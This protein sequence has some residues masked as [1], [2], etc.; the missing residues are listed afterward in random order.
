MTSKIAASRIAR[1]LMV[2]EWQILE[3]IR[4]GEIAG[5]LHG[6]SGTVTESV[7]RLTVWAQR[8]HHERAARTENN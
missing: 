6:Q 2:P 3:A 4:H 8:V 7:A 1:V 5:H